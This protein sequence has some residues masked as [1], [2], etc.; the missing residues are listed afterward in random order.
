MLH[1]PLTKLSEHRESTSRAD[2][3]LLCIQQDMTGLFYYFS[4]HA[5]T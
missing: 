2:A 4:L 3:R 1:K 5:L